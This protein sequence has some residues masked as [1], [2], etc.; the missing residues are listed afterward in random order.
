MEAFLGLQGSNCIFE[1]RTIA[2]HLIK[3]VY[4][5]DSKAA[6]A[7]AAKAYRKDLC[8]GLDKGS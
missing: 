1:A 2:P 8:V 6:K 5:G 4:R 7:K 3:N